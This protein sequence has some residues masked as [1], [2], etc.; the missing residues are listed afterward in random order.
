MSIKIEIAERLIQRGMHRLAAD[1]AIKTYCEPPYP[2]FQ[3]DDANDLDG[4]EIL[5]MLEE[6]LKELKK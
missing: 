5:Q 3:V 2:K 1:L 4:K 6:Y